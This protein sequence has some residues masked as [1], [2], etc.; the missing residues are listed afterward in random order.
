MLDDASTVFVEANGLRFACQQHGPEG[1]DPIVLIRGLGTQMI[2]WSPVLLRRLG[3]GN[4]R[5]VIF[6]N[7]DVGLTEKVD[8][9]YVLADMADDVAALMAALGY[10]RY[11]VLGISLGG[12][13][14]QL[15]AANHG[16]QVKSLFSVMSS[17]GSPHLPTASPEVRERLTLTGADREA[18]VRLDTENR[19]VW[20]SPGYPET[21]AIRRAMAEHTHDRCYC[22]EGVAR[23]MRAAVA[24]GSRVGRLAG[25]EVPTLV[26]HGAD[27][28]L[29]LPA[30]GAHTAESIPGARFEEIAGMGHNIPDALAPEI[31]SRVLEF[32]ATAG[33]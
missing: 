21:E 15:V 31:A 18:R 20:G 2:E 16:A 33:G 32:I 7:R 6:D 8:D 10:P 26:L 28:P 9:D 1:G 25:I 19:A 27:D 30:C 24:D 23:Q 3:E 22:P 5:V 14:A 4:L 17:S 13:V 11:H 12:M 29:L